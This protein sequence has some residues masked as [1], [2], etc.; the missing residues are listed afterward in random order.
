MDL[1]KQ[2]RRTTLVVCRSQSSRT[3]DN[4]VYLASFSRNHCLEVVVQRKLPYRDLACS[5]Q[6]LSQYCLMATRMSGQRRLLPTT[7][8]DQRRPNRSRQGAKVLE[9]N[10]NHDIGALSF[11]RWNRSSMLNTELLLSREGCTSSPRTSSEAVAVHLSRPY[12]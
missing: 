2:T 11:R 5:S 6:D 9:D 1:A 3:I 8:V 12:N 7:M 10:H 4:S